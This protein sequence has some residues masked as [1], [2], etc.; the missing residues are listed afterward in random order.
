[1]I[2]ASKKQYYANLVSSSS[3][4]LR[5][6]WQTINKLFHRKSASPPTFASASALADSL[7]SFFTYKISKFRLSL[8]NIS[9]SASPCKLCIS[10]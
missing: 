1:M 8:S 9:T 10:F 4:N 5:L 2:L 3:D 6:L 7:A